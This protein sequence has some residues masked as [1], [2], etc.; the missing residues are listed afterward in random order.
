MRQTQ[1]KR[2]LHLGGVQH[3][4]RRPVGPHEVRPG[5]RLRL[6]RNTR[7]LCTSGNPLVG[8]RLSARREV[9]QPRRTSARDRQQGGGNEL[10]RGRTADLIRH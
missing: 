4:S 5:G 3:G 9:E 6:Q 8:R 7:S 1:A 2:P 10:S